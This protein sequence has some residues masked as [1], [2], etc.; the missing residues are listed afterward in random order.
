VLVVVAQMEV[1][2]FK[3]QVPVLAATVTLVEV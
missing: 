3:T 1:V 2:V